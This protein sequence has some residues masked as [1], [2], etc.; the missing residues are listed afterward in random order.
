MSACTTS[1]K[2]LL[3][4]R[5][6]FW[7]PSGRCGHRP[8]GG[9]GG[10]SRGVHDGL[11]CDGQSAGDARHRSAQPDGDDRARAEHDRVRWRSRSSRMP[12]P[13]TAV[14]SN[15]DRT[16]R[17]IS[18]GRCGGDPPEDQAMPKRGV[19]AARPAAGRG[20]RRQ[21]PQV[22]PEARGSS[23]LVIGRTDALPVEG[24]G[25]AVWRARLYLDAGADLPSSTGSGRS[26]SWRRW[27]R[28]S[29]G[30]KVVSIVDGNETTALT[31]ADLRPGVL[32]GLLSTR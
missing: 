3:R 23:E 29:T 22:R 21:A 16:V 27:R 8:A 20:E 18:P 14:R 24:V 17:E 26:R 31:A 28:R 2:S 7:R 9:S 32:A 11:R 4:K 6:S 13:A 30:R 25:E 15:I 19:T 5:R 1:L 12:T 10:L